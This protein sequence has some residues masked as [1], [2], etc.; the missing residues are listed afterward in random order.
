VF[1]SLISETI[2]FVQFLLQLHGSLA[3]PISTRVVVKDTTPV[4][5]FRSKEYEIVSNTIIKPPPEAL[6]DEGSLPT[7]VSKQVSVSYPEQTVVVV[8]IEGMGQEKSNIITMVSKE[9]EEYLS[10]YK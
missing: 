3:S 1:C 9:I 4:K 6:P 7:E 8:E 5:E 10:V 2:L